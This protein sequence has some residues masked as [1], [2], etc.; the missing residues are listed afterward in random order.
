MVGVIEAPSYTERR[1]QGRPGLN[2][3]GQDDLYLSGRIVEC[4]VGCRKTLSQKPQYIIDGNTRDGVFQH[5][6]GSNDTDG[7]KLCRGTGGSRVPGGKAME[8]GH[9]AEGRA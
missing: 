5:G 6:S 1:I 4:Y 7:A 3:I 2:K 9:Q 8:R